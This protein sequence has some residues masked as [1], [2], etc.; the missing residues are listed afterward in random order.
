LQTFGERF[1]ILK[2]LLTGAGMNGHWKEC[3]KWPAPISTLW[4]HVSLLKRCSSRA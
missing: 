4:K 1:D 3:K 2:M